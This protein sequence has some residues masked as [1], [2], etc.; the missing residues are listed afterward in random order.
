MRCERQRQHQRTQ[1]SGLPLE[2]AGKLLK[3]F[4]DF[5]LV[6]F[7]GFIMSRMY[8]K[9]MIE[10]L[11][12]SNLTSPDTVVMVGAEIVVSGG[13]SMPTILRPMDPNRSDAYD[14]QRAG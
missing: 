11:V 10:Y 5:F 14:V 7:G 3:L 4:F 1:K 13:M 6:F 2:K 9:A 12:T 8:D